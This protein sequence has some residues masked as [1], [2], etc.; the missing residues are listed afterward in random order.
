M[1]DIG[2]L[3]HIDQFGLGEYPYT[4][5]SECRLHFSPSLLLH[6]IIGFELEDLLQAPPQVP[7]VPVE[8]ICLLASLD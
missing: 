7:S 8:Q 6:H 4:L 2:Q 5:R 1:L 3:G